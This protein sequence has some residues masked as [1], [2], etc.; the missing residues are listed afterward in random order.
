[1]YLGTISVVALKK[2]VTIND[3]FFPRQFER[4]HSCLTFLGL[5]QWCSCKNAL[6]LLRWKVYVAGEVVCRVGSG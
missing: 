1:M 5:R 2:N 3:N 6:E 4:D